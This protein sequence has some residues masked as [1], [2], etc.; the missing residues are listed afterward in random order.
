MEFLTFKKQE[1]FVC[2]KDHEVDLVKVV[3]KV[4]DKEMQTLKQNYEIEFVAAYCNQLN[5]VFETPEIKTLNKMLFLNV[6]NNLDALLTKDYLQKNTS[7][8]IECYV[9]D[10]NYETTINGRMIGDGK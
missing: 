10:W 2:G 1:C 3:K 7:T 4:T 8:K 9:P 6:R 5:E